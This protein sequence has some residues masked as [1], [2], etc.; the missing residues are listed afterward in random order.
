MA[1]DWQRLK[2]SFTFQSGDK[3]AD[4]F[5]I[6]TAGKTV[7]DMDVHGNQYGMLA[8]SK[9]FRMSGM[10]CLTRHSPH[11]RE[12]GQKELFS[13]RRASCHTEQH[14]NFCKAKDRIGAGNYKKL[15]RLPYARRTVTIDS[16]FVTG[17]EYSYSG[18]DALTFHQHLS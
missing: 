15:H 17:R 14:G 8:S 16:G 18:N 11:A 3:L 7:A 6:D 4:F 1:G 12:T 9:C 13:Q 10:T 2:P 5:S